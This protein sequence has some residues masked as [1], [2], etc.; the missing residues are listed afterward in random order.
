LQKRPRSSTWEVM[1]EMWSG[2]LQTKHMGCRCM[3]WS[4]WKCKSNRVWSA[5]GMWPVWVHRELSIVA[6]LGALAPSLCILQVGTCKPVGQV[7]S[8]CW[9]M[10]NLCLWHVFP[11]QAWLQWSR[12]CR[13]RRLRPQVHMC[14][15][16]WCLGF[17]RTPAHTG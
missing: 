2:E 1:M 11:S 3:L 6:K 10:L 13:L 16:S 12:A 14:L 5:I 17:E 4:W 7:A 8:R 15:G 9:E